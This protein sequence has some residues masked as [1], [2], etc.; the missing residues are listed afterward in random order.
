MDFQPTLSPGAAED[1][2]SLT[3]FEQRVIVA[4]IR[5][6]LT[7]DANIETRRRKRLRENPVGPWELKCG[8]LRI[9][10]DIIDTDVELLA[11]GYKEHND[12]FIRGKRVEL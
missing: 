1:L 5:T 9:F 4:A 8:R 7:K 2:D 12:L 3:A 11:I 10:Y 6:F